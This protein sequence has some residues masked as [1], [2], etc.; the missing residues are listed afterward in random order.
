VRRAAKL[1]ELLARLQATPGVRHAAVSSLVPLQNMDMVMAFSMPSH[2]DPAAPR[3]TVQ[4]RARTVSPDY[5]A[6][7]GMRLHDGRFFT[8]QDTRAAMPA[9]IVNRA[10][11]DTYLTQHPIGEMLPAGFNKAEPPTQ[12]QVVGVLDNIIN[13][14]MGDT[15]QPEIF[16]SYRQIDA[17]LGAPE[18]FLVVRT[19]DDPKKL[20]PALQGFV[21][22]LDPSV[23]IESLTTMHD[24]LTTSLARPRLYAVLLGAFAGFAL[25]IAG[26]GLFGVLSYSVAQRTREIGVRTALGAQPGD[27]VRL[28]VRQGMVMTLGGVT[29][30]LLTAAMLVRFLTALL[31][32]VTARDP[33]S[34]VLV[35]L[36]VLLV[37]AAAC[38][39]PARRAARVDPLR[40]MRSS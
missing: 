25:L 12:W 18:P 20:I 14:Q 23:A 19:A 6:A 34:F 38:Y 35:P 13:G 21:R 32:G 36:A 3:I 30:G 7:M 28:V 26:V 1:D 24:Q 40:A 27:I 11:A 15:P 31:Y 29:I 17:G 22:Q 5:F 39:L 37:S 9:I 4:T 2:R 33:L 8:E 10:F 16:V